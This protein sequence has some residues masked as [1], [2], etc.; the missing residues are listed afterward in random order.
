MSSTTGA[1]WPSATG[2]RWLKGA[3]SPSAPS[4]A[5]IP[6]RSGTPAATSAPKARSKMIKVIGKDECSALE[7]SP[8]YAFMSARL[9]LAAPNSSIRRSGY[10]FAVAAVTASAALT[11][12]WAWLLLP[13]RSKVTI[14][15]RPSGERSTAPPAEKGERMSPMVLRD[16]RRPT[17]S[18]TARAYTG[19][20]KCTGP[21]PCNNTCSPEWY[22]KAFS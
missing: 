7:K 19:S 12:C 10:A 17:R 18:A 6:K 5:V 3:I 22:G 1:I 2:M 13:T 20:P 11:L 9:E 4:T 15:E 8:S 14:M 16:R 21:F